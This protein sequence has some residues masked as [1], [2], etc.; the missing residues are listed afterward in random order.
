MYTNSAY[1]NHSRID[2]MDKSRPLIVSCCGTYHIFTKKRL[3]TYRPKGRVDFQL[4]YI[5]SGQAHFYFKENEE[6]IVTAGHMILYRPK[7]MQKYVYYDT[8][9]TEVYWIH[10]TGSDVKKILRKHHFPAKEHV[11][12]CGTVPEY[13]QIFTKII[14]ELQLE[15]EDFENYITTLLYQL[16]IM[17]GRQQNVSHAIPSAAQ[18]DI[19]YATHYFNENYQQTIS[20][21]DFAASLNMS[22]CWFIRNFK[23]YHKITPMA[24]ILSLRIRNAQNLL[25]STSYNI[26]E[27]A[28][29]VGYDN[30]LYFSRL[31]KKQTGLSP[32]EYRKQHV[33]EAF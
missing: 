17:V 9:Q 31:F 27:I 16:L 13:Q 1:L 11:I 15:R 10:F 12:Y 33:T 30:P 8:D 7:E 22:T 4:L 18:N 26:T 25:E 5:A 19:E 32:S 24:Y 6:T 21:D 20:I 28:S 2:F 3:P 23:Q 29:I 14:Q